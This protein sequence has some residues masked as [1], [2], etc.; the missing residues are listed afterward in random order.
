MKRGI[1][2]RFAFARREPTTYYSLGHEMRWSELRYGD[3]EHIIKGEIVVPG[4]NTATI[5]SWIYENSR[6]LRS[7]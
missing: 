5:R 3:M 2:E 1:G 6:L 7:R 4:K